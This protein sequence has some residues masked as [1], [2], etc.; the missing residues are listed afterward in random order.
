MDE[1]KAVLLIA[2]SLQENAKAEAE[3]ITGYTE[4]LTQIADIQ[5]SGVDAATFEVISEIIPHIQE[6]ISDELNHQKTLM[7]L[8]SAITQIKINED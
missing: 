3:A 2:N 1:T 8:Y 6:I 5:S 4:M 7:D